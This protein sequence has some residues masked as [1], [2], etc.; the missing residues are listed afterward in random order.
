MTLH[1]HC[2]TGEMII[3]IIRRHG[4]DIYVG[5]VVV[6]ERTSRAGVAQGFKSGE[7]CL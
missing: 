7:V 6:G 1:L 5:M 4:S 2:L 3:I